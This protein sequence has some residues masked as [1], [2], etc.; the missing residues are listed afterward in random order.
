MTEFQS[1]VSM[2][3]DDKLIDFAM[4]EAKSLY[5]ID[6]VYH[7]FLQEYMCLFNNP[8]EHYSKIMALA[9]RKTLKEIRD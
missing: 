4:T 5:N 2:C 6:L 1:R 7:H 9:Y 3:I 8:L